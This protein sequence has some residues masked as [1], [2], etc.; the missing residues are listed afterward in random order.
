M[1]KAILL[2]VLKQQRNNTKKNTRQDIISLVMQLVNKHLDNE[3]E[4]TGQIDRVYDNHTRELNGKEYLITST[5]GVNLGVVIE[6]VM[7]SI[8]KNGLNKSKT[9]GCDAMLDGKKYE[10]KF[11]TCDAYAH[12]INNTEKVDYYLIV[13]YSKK[14]GGMVFKV[15]YA[16][17]NEIDINNQARITIN[18][19]QKFFDKALTQKV[20]SL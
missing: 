5:G 8:F 14:L 7:R 4:L 20:F 9:A 3:T 6:I 17:R 16:N 2:E 19:K 10:I 13:A 15:P 1:K 18:Q 11:T 12:P